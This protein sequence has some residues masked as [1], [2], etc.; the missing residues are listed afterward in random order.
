MLVCMRETRGSLTTKSA[1]GTRPIFRG[2]SVTP[3]LRLVSSQ[4]SSIPPMPTSLGG[5]RACRSAGKVR[6]SESISGCHSMR[7]TSQGSVRPLIRMGPR[8][9]LRTGVRAPS[10]RT[11]LSV[12]RICS[13]PARSLRREARLTASPKQSPSTT[14]TW[15]RAMPICIMS[16][17]RLGH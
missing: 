5:M 11:T 14:T 7:N 3:K 4:A 15:P 8:L 1:S 6:N 2:N 10:S 13:A 12:A 16:L 17:R 9:R